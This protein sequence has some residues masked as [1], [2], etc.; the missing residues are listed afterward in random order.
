M[1]NAAFVNVHYYS[2]GAGL[3]VI[4]Q[5]R[6]SHLKTTLKPASSWQAAQKPEQTAQ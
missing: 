4:L 2:G 1:Q 6:N 3:C 5:L